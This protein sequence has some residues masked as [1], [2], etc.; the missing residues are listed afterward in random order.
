MKSVNNKGCYHHPQRDA[1]A[2]CPECGKYYCR[3]CVTEHEDRMLCSR[4][5][6]FQIE[7]RSKRSFTWLQKTVVPIQAL[8]GFLMLWYIFFL[9]GQLLLTI[10]HAFHEGTIWQ[11]QWWYNP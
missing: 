9:L 3:E 6:S 4:C 5:L 7:K 10:P 2:R 1:V 8:V 11:S